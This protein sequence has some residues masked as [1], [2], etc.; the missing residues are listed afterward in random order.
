[1]EVKT[2][3]QEKQYPA[4]EELSNIGHLRKGL[5]SAVQAEFRDMRAKADMADRL[6]T[7]LK[8]AAM[9]LRK[10]DSGA[11]QCIANYCADILNEYKQT[12][13]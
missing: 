2:T 9:E 10:D 7:V 1:M 5:V 6:Y 3:P 12:G 11:S 8:R 13:E 4:H